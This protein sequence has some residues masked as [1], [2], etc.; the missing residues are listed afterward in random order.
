MN[1]PKMYRNDKVLFMLKV[2]NSYQETIIETYK[3]LNM[4]QF[5]PINIIAGALP[6]HCFKKE[7]NIVKWKI[8]EHKYFTSA[9]IILGIILVF[10]NDYIVSC[11]RMYN[12]IELN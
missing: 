12:C 8:Y 10:Q 11:M 6:A 5:I 9:P 2:S 3:L 4:H 1:L 7:E